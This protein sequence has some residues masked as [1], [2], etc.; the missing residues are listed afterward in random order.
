MG[1]YSIPSNKPFRTKSKLIKNKNKNNVRIREG[2]S[3][4]QSGRTVIDVTNNSIVIVK[5]DN[6]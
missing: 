6:K 3:L 5:N 2:L 4:L 1:A